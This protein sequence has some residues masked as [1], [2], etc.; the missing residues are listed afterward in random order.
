MKRTK[1]TQGKGNR[2]HPT[3]TLTDPPAWRLSPRGADDDEGADDD[4]DW[5]DEDDDEDDW[6]DEEE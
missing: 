4:D 5:T 1:L 3:A 6:L 2:T